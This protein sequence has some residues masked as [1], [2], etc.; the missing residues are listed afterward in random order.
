MKEKERKKILK[1]LDILPNPKT[2]SLIAITIVV[3]V[4]FYVLILISLTQ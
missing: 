1:F 2:L 3:G 4:I